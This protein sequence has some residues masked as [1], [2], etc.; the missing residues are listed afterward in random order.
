MLEMVI[1][2]AILSVALLSVATYFQTTLVMSE[3]TQTKIQSEYLLE[4]GIEAVKLMRDTNYTNNL[5]NLSAGTYYL[6]WTGA[7]WATT[8]ASVFIDGKFERFFNIANV[9]RD[10]NSD[11]GAGANDPNTKLITMN[12]AWNDRGSTTTQSVATYIMNIFNN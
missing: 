9:T 3:K 8:S 6:T 5:K 10:A 11:I 2:S 1:G 4:E 7:V 12:V